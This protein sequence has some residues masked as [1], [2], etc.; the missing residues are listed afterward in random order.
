MTQ[1]QVGDHVW[2]NNEYIGQAQYR[3][4]YGE[5]IWLAL[6]TE[7]GTLYRCW[8]RYLKEMYPDNTWVQRPVFPQLDTNKGR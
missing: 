1:L 8:N 3:N 2:F 4:D 5:G 7:N 6:P